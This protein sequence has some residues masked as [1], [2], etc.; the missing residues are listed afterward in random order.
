MTG[1][2]NDACRT[3]RRFLKEAGAGLAM[4]AAPFARS[5]GAASSDKRP[6]IL[7][8]LADD[9]GWPHASAYGAP[10]V[11]TPTFDRIAGEGV[12]FHNSYVSSP[13]C[14]PYR[15]AALTGQHF[16]RLEEAGNLWSTLPAKFPVYPDLLE[17]AGYHVGYSGK[18]WGPGRLEPGGRKRNPAGPRY[19]NF[20][21]FMQK[22]P[23]GRPFCF[24]LGSHDPHRPYKRGSG[25]DSGMN[26]DDIEIP[27]CFPDSEEVRGD[28]ADYFWEVQRFDRQVA[29]AL[30]I[31]EEAGET[32]NTIVVM[33]GDHGM[34]F[35]R[36]KTQLYDSGSRTP[37][38]I[39]W[40]AEVQG[41]REVT[42]FVNC[43]DFAPTFLDAAGLTPPAQMTGK[44]ILDVLTSSDTGRV[45]EANDHTIFGRER[46]CPAQEGDCSGGYPM[47]AIRTDDYLY[48]RNFEPDRWPAGTPDWQNAY[49][50]KAWLGDCDN[51]PTKT[52]MWKHRDEKG[53]QHLYDLAFA[54]RPAEEL[55]DLKKDPDQL[56]NVADKPKYAEAK[57]RLF[58]RLMSQLKDL[59]DPRALGQGEKFDNYPYYGGVPSW[60]WG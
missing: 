33:T 47:R 11:Q 22:R 12:L 57:K 42:D 39:K 8:A 52:Y 59:K 36:C 15:G 20:K 14:T 24:W 27:A 10:V 18:G 4:A 41:G 9:W 1:E 13:S 34:P 56:N 51:G 25:A 37:L 54:K 58:R 26:L 29:N 60:P 3:R 23:D 53:V 7:F 38:A 48:I 5:A 49:L 55:Y 21:Q 32:Q 35:P 45:R 43:I 6:N 46:H 2:R 50:D 31:L 17:K 40:P 16:C 44:S 28:V 19:G 30:K